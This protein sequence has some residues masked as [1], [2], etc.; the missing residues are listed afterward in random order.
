M[1]GI[2]GIDAI[3]SRMMIT[4]HSTV[5]HGICPRLWQNGVCI[6]NILNI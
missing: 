4:L 1:I 3:L 2:N 5:Y 6:V